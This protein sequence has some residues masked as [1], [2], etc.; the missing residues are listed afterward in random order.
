MTNQK[1]S[2]DTDRCYVRA[3]AQRGCRA[4]LARII[5]KRAREQ[6]IPISVLFA[7]VET[8]S[9]FRKVFGHDNTI[10]AGAGVVTKE[11]YLRYKKQRLASGN[12]LMQGVGEAQL[13]F[14]AYQD[15]ADAYGGCWR[16]DPNIRVAA[17]I[18]ALY[19]DQ[20]NTMREALAKYNA[21][22]TNWT[23]GLS[24]AG[25]VLGRR[26]RWASLIKACLQLRE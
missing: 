5:I 4:G 25:L 21:G 13:T 18:L 3:A 14:W 24:Y 1:K 15:R 6:E 26:E 7:L 17:E 12:R 16:A 11:K 9:G 10:F 20:G 19:V 23:K 2:I 8:E 22:A